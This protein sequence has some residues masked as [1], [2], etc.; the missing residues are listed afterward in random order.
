MNKKIY[1]SK[2]KKMVSGVC[3]GLEDYLGIDVTIIRLV[4]IIFSLV[5]GTF[6]GL[7]A[8]IVAAAIIPEEPVNHDN[9]TGNND[10]PWNSNNDSW[11]NQNQWS[12]Q[13]N[14]NNQNNQNGSNNSSGQGNPN[15]SNGQPYESPY[16]NNFNDPA[17][18]PTSGPDDK[19]DDTK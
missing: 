10:N 12:N 18:N 8:Y 6:P 11:T 1:R 13:Q 5:S 3:G 19:T 17:Q 14:R 15:S 16:H 4:W 7:I 2:T 9:W